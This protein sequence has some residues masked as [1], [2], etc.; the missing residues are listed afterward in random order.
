MPDQYV[1]CYLAVLEHAQNVGLI[2]N[3][4]LANFEDSSSDS[5]C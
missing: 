5:E 1:F 2:E 3:I 4:D